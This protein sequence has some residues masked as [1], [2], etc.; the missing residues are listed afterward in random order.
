MI[1]VTKSRRAI[2]FAILMSP[3]LT[4]GCME[5]DTS[6]TISDWH[7]YGGENGTHFSPLTDITPSNVGQMQQAWRLDTGPGGLQTSPLVVDG[8][9][10]AMTPAQE[11]VAL[12]A[13]TGVQRWR[14][15]IKDAGSQPVRGLSFW[16]SSAEARLFVG[17][18]PWLSALDPATG[19]LIPG[20]SNNGRVDLSLGMGRDGGSGAVALT[21]PGTIWH[22][23]IIVGFRT[24]ESRP[25]ASGVVRA[26]NVRTGAPVWTFNLI[27]KQG[28]A[29]SET[30]TPDGLREAG[31]ANS[32]AGMT[33]DTSTGTLFVP[34]GS[35]VD[36]FF[37]GTRIG[38]N[39]Y[40][41]SL[42]ALNADT[43]KKIWHYQIVHH[44]LQDRDLPS[45]PVLLNVQR[46]GKQ[47]AAVAQ[48]TKHGALFVFDR[49]NGR[50]LFPIEE[51]AVPKSDVPGEQ[52]WPTQPFPTAPAPYARQSLAAADLTRRTPAAH[53]AVAA[54][55]AKAR[56]AG[57][58]TSMAVD[59]PTIVF[60]GFDGGAEWGGQAVDPKRGILFINS[61]DVPWIGSLA[62]S[63]G[64]SG[65]RA[66]YEQNCAAC[67]GLDRKGSPPDFP[68]LDGILTRKLESDVV[69]TILG[70]QGRMP[71]FAQ[72]SQPQLI[73]ITKYLQD[74]STS[75]SREFQGGGAVATRKP[76]YVFT[77]YQRFVDP[78]GYPAVAPPW[79]TLN[80]IDLNTGRYL[81]RIPLGE[82]PELAA[83]GLGATG[84]ENYGGPMLTATGV[85]FI[86]AT[87]YDRK[88]RAFDAANGRLLWSALLPYAGTA[89]PVIYR[90]KGRQFVVIATSAARNK[91]AAPGSAYIAFALPN[92]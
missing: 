53:A 40:A 45:P 63:S 56:S 81:W 42:V 69:R 27:P 29:G 46:D 68:S 38:A 90:A 59:Q 91:R 6:F 66:L 88:F 13:A 60:P 26:L 51:R 14:T 41:N 82:Y 74:P 76:G 21:T 79:G 92:G 50:P 67:H 78:D 70:G 24:T 83:K 17:T 77:G 2:R 5:S 47:I 72:F 75:D 7:V 12:D 86:G 84:T 80:A 4:L 22:D 30:W 32:W 54:I 89:T 43:G 85:L 25:A 44:D 33:L 3:L 49:A 15:K 11:V 20:F 18:G 61:N 52:S 55:F 16:R 10:Y 48:A 37:G 35:A 23:N 9:L 65:G 39:L 58:F 62:K 73:E 8:I 19:E 31:G 36:D 57:P 34:T 71:A 1:R 87:V 64:T 28:E